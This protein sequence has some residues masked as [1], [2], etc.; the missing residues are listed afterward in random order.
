MENILPN[1]S[2]E[3]ERIILSLENNNVIVDSVAGSGKTTTI[4]HIAQYN[5][6]KN[7]L[8]LTYNARLKVETRER[9][10]KYEIKN[11]ETH[12]YHSFCKKYYN[13]NCITDFE[14]LQILNQKMNIK[15]VKNYDI[16]ILDESQDINKSYYEL[17]CKIYKDNKNERCKLCI[18]GDKKQSIYAFNG[19]DERYILFG[20]KIFNYNNIEWDK[21]KLSNSF[22]IT[23]E[24]SEFINKCMLNE[25]IIKSNKVSNKKPRYIICDT[26]E[27]EPYEE[28]EYYL[29]MGYL[30]E[31]IFII[32]PSIKSINSPIRKLENKIKV[33]KNNDINVYVPNSD[34]EKLDEDVI[35]N[36][37]VF[38]TI[39]QVKGLERKVV[40]LFNFDD[41]YYKFYNKNSN[42]FV[43]SNELYVAT[44]RA[45]EH[46]TLLHH[47]SSDYL[48]FLNKNNISKYCDYLQFENLRINPNKNEKKISTSVTELMKNLQVEIIEDCLKYVS[49]DIK[50]PKSKK[51]N[52]P[53]KIKEDR[54][55]EN[56][57]ELNGIAIPS[58]FEYKLKGQTTILNELTKNYETNNTSFSDNTEEN[59]NNNIEINE[60]TILKISA[61]WNSYKTGF[62]YKIYQIKKYNW[63]SKENLEKAIER[64]KSLNISKDARFEQNLKTELANREIIGYIDC[65]DNN[66][67]YEFKC[68]DK[69]EKEH[70]LQLSIYM[71]LNEINIDKLNI[72][73][74]KY[75]INNDL[76]NLYNEYKNIIDKI[77]NIN[78]LLL[79]NYNLKVV[80]SIIESIDERITKYTNENIKINK[81]IEKLKSEKDKSNVTKK[82]EKEEN[83]LKYNNLRIIQKKENKKLLEES[84]EI[85]IIIKNQKNIYN[86]IET[87][88]EKLCEEYDKD[89]NEY[90]FYKKKEEYNCKEY[91]EEEI[92]KHEERLKYLQENIQDKNNKL[93]ILKQSNI[94]I[95]SKKRENPMENLNVIFEEYD[96][97]NNKYIIYEKKIETDIINNYYL[98]NILT[99]ELIEIKSDMTKLKTMID[100]LI[101]KKYFDTNIITDNKFLENC[102]LIYEKYIVK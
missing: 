35:K 19:S 66:N 55:F 81:K 99:D 4:L 65:I 71:Y 79:N 44:T 73:K 41:S 86:D 12:S 74:I 16:I 76:L 82:I 9:V 28:V 25:E 22:R 69:L 26:F 62:L 97:D 101:K 98:Y 95:F 13:E 93:N 54:C 83:E 27:N 3:Q 39:H 33:N 85:F 18:L 43:C 47:N 20:D 57:A 90:I 100:Y 88:Y 10:K 63:L 70:F 94:L 84:N 61:R 14:I 11:V 2:V 96:K 32:A 50:K 58:F 21:Q 52:I 24:M 68:V 40:I 67:I 31:D 51:I 75:K 8:L 80:N 37:L 78:N 17:I 72:D 38:T 102:S 89:N 49:T 7:I 46:L 23:F 56:V 30:P 59:I 91:Y 5:L 60:E 34:E 64:L 29:K 45:I 42:P 6:S 53:I 77:K 1:Y 15:K 48:P 87:Y 92:K 36:K